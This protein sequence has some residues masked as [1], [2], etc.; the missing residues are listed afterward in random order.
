MGIKTYFI[1]PYQPV[2]FLLTVASHKQKHGVWG[3]LPSGLGD[4]GGDNKWIFSRT[5]S[6]SRIHL[7]QAVSPFWI[8]C[9]L[10]KATQSVLCC[11]CGQSF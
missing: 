8:H 3:K 5:T 10:E 7:G 1:F 11:T 4:V 9:A 6:P 2:D